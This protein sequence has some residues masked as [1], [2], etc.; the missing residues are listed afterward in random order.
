VTALATPSRR[1]RTRMA[2]RLPCGEPGRPGADAVPTPSGDRGGEPTLEDLISGV[3]AGLAV[4]QRVA[5]PLCDG[6]MVPHFGAHAQPSE[7]RCGECG[8]TLS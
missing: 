6:E 4:H 1:G 3:W 5:C 7:G 8:T 2:S